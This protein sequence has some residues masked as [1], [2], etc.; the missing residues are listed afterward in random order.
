MDP[1]DLARL[2]ARCRLA[3]GGPGGQ[4]DA[5]LAAYLIVAGVV[6][7]VAGSE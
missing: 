7:D 1:A 4:D 2:G 3:A 5:E 6:D